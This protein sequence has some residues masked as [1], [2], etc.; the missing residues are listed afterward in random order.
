MTVS[1]VHRA[2]R[3]GASPSGA[4]RAQVRDDSNA[5]ACERRET[6]P[7]LAS[8][9]RTGMCGNMRCSVYLSLDKI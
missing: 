8:Q 3:P 6:E 1:A 4:P 2:E 9:Q 5:W 7:P